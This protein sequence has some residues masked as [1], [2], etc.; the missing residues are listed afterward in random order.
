MRYNFTGL[1]S[2]EVIGSRKNFGSNEL[3]A[4]EVESFWSKLIKN[5]KDPII[6]IL[7]IAL[8]IK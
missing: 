8:V 6:I 7:S 2:E 1:T 3:D 5:F 4:I